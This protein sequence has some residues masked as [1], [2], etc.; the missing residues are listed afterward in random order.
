MAA[1]RPGLPVAWLAWPAVPVTA[2]QT[3]T[4]SA[5][6]KTNGEQAVKVSVVLRYLDERGDVLRVHQ[7]LPP[8]AQLLE[9]WYRIGVTRTASTP[10][11][12]NADTQATQAQ[13][14]VQW[15][16]SGVAYLDCVQL[17]A[18]PIATSSP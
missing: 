16:T 1:C 12:L 5:W 7:V 10:A 4:A 3:Y 9:Q 6:F 13:V 18:Y 8:D 17:E 2:G 15:D 11:M 14:V